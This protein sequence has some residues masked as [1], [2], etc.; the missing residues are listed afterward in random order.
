MQAYYSAPNNQSDSTWY[1][2]S[3]ATHHLT[4]ELDNLNLKVDDYMGSDQIRIGNGK[5]FSIKHIGNTHISFPNI[6]FNLLNVLHV[7]HI[8]KIYSQIHKRH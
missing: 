5:G 8:T 4:S 1:P 7:P 3:G 6:N 2:D